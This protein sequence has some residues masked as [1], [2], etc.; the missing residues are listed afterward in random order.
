[1]ITKELI[2]YIKNERKL[3]KNDEMIRE[4]LMKEGWSKE[5]LDEGFYRIRFSKISSILFFVNLSLI[6]FLLGLNII[7]RSVDA[8]SL[9]KFYWNAFSLLTLPISLLS[10]LQIFIG[11]KSIRKKDYIWGSLNLILGFLWL[12]FRVLFLYYAFCFL[13][14]FVFCEKLIN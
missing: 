6:L 13:T 4:T 1:M 14:V 2:D 8:D 10:V 9:F 11:F 3:G 5:D 7:S 12:S